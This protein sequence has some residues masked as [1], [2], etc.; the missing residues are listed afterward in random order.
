[1]QLLPGTLYTGNRWGYDPGVGFKA[2]RGQTRLSVSNLAVKVPAA[3]D[4]DINWRTKVVRRK[5]CAPGRQKMEDFTGP[6]KPIGEV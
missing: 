4:S 5:P 2:K 3:S 1:M 6:V